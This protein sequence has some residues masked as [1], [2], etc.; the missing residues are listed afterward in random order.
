MTGL[1]ECPGASSPEPHEYAIDEETGE[2]RQCDWCGT[3]VCEGEGRYC[4]KGCAR[5]A[6]SDHA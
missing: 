2:T 6:E 5:A 4:S 3:P 1:R